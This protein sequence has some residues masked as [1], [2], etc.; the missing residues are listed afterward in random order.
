MPRPSAPANA[1]WHRVRDTLA[2]VASGAAVELLQEVVPGFKEHFDRVRDHVVNS[3][4][5][6]AGGFRP[7]HAASEAGSNG[8]A[9]NAP[10]AA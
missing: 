6:R 5:A 10:D 8:R 4:N 1:N 7:T 2:A 9:Y 3:N